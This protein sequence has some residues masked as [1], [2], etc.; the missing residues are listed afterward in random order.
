MPTSP[1]ESDSSLAHLV[2][3]TLSYDTNIMLAAIISLLL[4]ILFVLL[5]LHLYTRWFLLQARRRSC[6]SVTIPRVFGSRLHQRFTIIDDHS[7]EKLGLPFSIIASIML[8]VSSIEDPIQCNHS[9]KID[10][11]KIEIADPETDSAG[12]TI[13]EDEL[14]SEIDAAESSSSIGESHSLKKLL[15]SGSSCSSS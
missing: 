1:P 12:L 5:L 6:N 10:H 4:V 3:T 2:R 11:L 13:N 9:R 7:S 14:R 15:T 8:F